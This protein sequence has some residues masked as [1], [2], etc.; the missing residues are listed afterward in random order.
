MPGSIGLLER[1]PKDC[2]PAFIRGDCDCGNDPVMSQLEATDRLY[3][4]KLKRSKRVKELIAQVHVLGAWTRYNAEWES[5]ESTL[6]I[7]GWKRAR[8]VVVAR[9]RLPK[10][11]LIGLEY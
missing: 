1:L 7:Y 4:F 5:K 2:Q 8:R 6:A 9:R 11:P 10:D 3:L